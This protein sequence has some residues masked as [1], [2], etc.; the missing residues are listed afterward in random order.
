M[1]QIDALAFG[2]SLGLEEIKS[3]QEYILINNSALQG[4][5]GVAV[6][7]WIFKDQAAVDLYFVIM[8]ET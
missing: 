8:A 5:L 6:I 4:D 1:H 3:D 2:P 7:D